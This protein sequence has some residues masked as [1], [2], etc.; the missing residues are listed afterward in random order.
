[1]QNDNLQMGH[2]LSGEQLSI[3]SR[4]QEILNLTAG[5]LRFVEERQTPDVKL[6][7]FSMRSDA[8]HLTSYVEIP[9]RIVTHTD[10][11]GRQSPP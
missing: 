5:Y 3:D 9:K 4:Q 2:C 8:Y 6:M 1:M 11:T 10:Q 7:K